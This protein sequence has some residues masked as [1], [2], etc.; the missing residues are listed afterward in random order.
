MIVTILTTGT[1]YVPSPKQLMSKLR[2]R[3][4]GQK[5]PRRLRLYPRRH[6]LNHRVWPRFKFI[7]LL[8]RRIPHNL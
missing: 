1:G 8:R 3:F 2:L 6:E 7:T 4:E 5:N